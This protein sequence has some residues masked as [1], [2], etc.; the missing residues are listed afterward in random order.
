MVEHSRHLGRGEDGLTAREPVLSR[1]PDF[2]ALI[3]SGEDEALSEKLRQ[4]ETIGRPLGTQA[5]LAKLERK[6]GRML[7]PAKRGRKPI[8]EEEDN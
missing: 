6:T 1:Y 3:K 5:F 7:R 4:A 8:A 2:A